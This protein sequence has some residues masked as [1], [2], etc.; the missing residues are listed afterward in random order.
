MTRDHAHIFISTA[1]LI[2]YIKIM[3]IL[4][5]LQNTNSVVCVGH[6]GIEF[7]KSISK[8]QHNGHMC[9]LPKCIRNCG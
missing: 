7:R 4:Y 9:I 6:H 2:L 8:R 3:S 5:C 1:L